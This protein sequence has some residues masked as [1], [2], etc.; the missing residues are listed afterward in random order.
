L[1]VLAGVP[2]E[3]PL[4]DLAVRGAVERQPHLLQVEHRVDGFLRHDL[5]GVLVGE[6]VTTLDG[7]EG[8][9]LPV[10]LFDV[11][12]CRAHTTLGGTRVGAC[13][14]EL[15]EHRGAGALT[16]FDRCAHTRAARSDDHHVVFVELHISSLSVWWRQSAGMFGSKVKI[17]SV[18]SSRITT[19]ATYSTIFSQK[20]VLSLRA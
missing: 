19:V 10:V 9:P 2:A 11:G 18:P 13:R 15:G 3:P 17:T 6:V 4:V 1:A 7:V 20:R 8:V 5:G 16:G 14:V 12:Q